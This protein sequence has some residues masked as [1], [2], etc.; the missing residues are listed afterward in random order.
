MK[1]FYLTLL[2]TML[3]FISHTKAGN[4]LCYPQPEP[5]IAN[6]DLTPPLYEPGEPIRYGIPIYDLHTREII[7]TAS[8]VC[9]YE[10]YLRLNNLP[11]VFFLKPR[12]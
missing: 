4:A 9:A 7:T 12:H 2:I 5:F 1:P 10:L 11:A 6:D 8:S 3:P